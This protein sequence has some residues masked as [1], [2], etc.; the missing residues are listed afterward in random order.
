M[1]AKWGTYVVTVYKVCICTA[2]QFTAIFCRF[3]AEY[4]KGGNHIWTCSGESLPEIQFRCI[5]GAFTPELH[6]NF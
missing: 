2:F 6:L 5:S 3:T 4:E 1:E